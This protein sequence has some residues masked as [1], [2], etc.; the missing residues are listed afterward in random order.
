VP[1]GT[2]L[3]ERRGLIARYVSSPAARPKPRSR[4]ITHPPTK[5]GSK[6]FD[7]ST[8]RS[9][10]SALPSPSR[11]HCS[12]LQQNLHPARSRCRH[13]HPETSTSIPRPSLASRFRLDLSVSTHG[14]ERATTGKVHRT[15]NGQVWSM[16]RILRKEGDRAGASRRCWVAVAASEGSHMLPWLLRRQKRQAIIPT[17]HCFILIGDKTNP[18]WTAAQLNLRFQQY[19]SLSCQ[20]F[21]RLNQRLPNQT[22]RVSRRSEA[23]VLG[24]HCHYLDID[25]AMR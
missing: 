21:P 12:I 25:E 9:Q 3:S 17:F 13:Q 15:T 10:S 24:V 11:L 16:I 14:H 4:L 22:A 2:A 7:T 23:P 5:T 1:R 8:Y 6:P 18:S 19:H 20:R